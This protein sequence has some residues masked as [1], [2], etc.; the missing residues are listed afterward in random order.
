MATAPASTAASA[1]T[2]A[3]MLVAAPV[4]IGVGDEEGPGKVPLGVG[5]ASV[6]GVAAGGVEVGYEVPI[7]AVG[8]AGA[9]ELPLATFS[10]PPATP[11]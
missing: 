5:V 6:V 2:L 4:S 8:P 7:G 1:N 9:V 11:P 3:E 10:S